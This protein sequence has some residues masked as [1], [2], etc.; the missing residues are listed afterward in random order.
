MEVLDLDLLRPDPKIVKLGGKEIDVS[1]IPCGITFDIDRITRDISSLDMKKVQ[2]G[3]KETHKAF[4]LS[5]E[6]CAVYCQ[7]SHPEMNKAW[8]EKNANPQQVNGLVAMIRETL[9]AGYK[10]VEGY[11]KNADAVKTS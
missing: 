1:F 10:E 2:S 4:D 7:I 8:F 3:G 11:S 6:L 9:Y 5:M